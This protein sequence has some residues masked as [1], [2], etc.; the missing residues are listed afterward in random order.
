MPKSRTIKVALAA[1]ALAATAMARWHPNAAGVPD[2]GA[3]AQQLNK[4]PGAA[5]LP[6]LFADEERDAPVEPL[7]PQ[8]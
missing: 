8:F 5:Y 3:H 7:P 1:A 4:E 2:A 6:D